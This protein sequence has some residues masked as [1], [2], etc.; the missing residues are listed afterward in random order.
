MGACC[1]KQTLTEGNSQYNLKSSSLLA[2]LYLGWILTGC[3]EDIK[4]LKKHTRYDEDTI[5]EWYAGFL[6]DCPNGK[7]TPATFCDMYKVV[8]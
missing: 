7:L 1:V 8:F 6:Q 3:S 5:R 2:W 4:F